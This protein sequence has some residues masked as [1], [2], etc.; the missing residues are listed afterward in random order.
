MQE[1][2]T[3]M[4]GM[5]ENLGVLQ[6]DGTV[7][8]MGSVISSIVGALTGGDDVEA[9]TAQIQALSD[10]IANLNTNLTTLSTVDFSA[11]I[12]SA[13]QLQSGMESLNGA[14]DDVYSS[15]QNVSRGAI[16]ATTAINNL[17]NTA[18]SRAGAFGG[19]IGAMGS[20]SGALSGAAGSAN[21]L[22]AAINAIPS[23]KS[24][25][26]AYNQVG[27]PGAASVGGGGG[28]AWATGGLIPQ[29]RAFG[30]TI[31]AMRPKGSD[32]VPAMLTP[33]EFVLRKKAV[34]T[35]GVPF[36][37]ALNGL[38]IPSAIDRLTAGLRMPAGFGMVSNDNRRIYNNNQKVNQYISTNNP[39]YANR[40]ANRWA[41][42][43]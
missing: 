18:Q 29:Y 31:F 33:G 28:G 3:T 30:G 41:K 4:I 12:D 5:Y 24:V 23:Y 16:Q 37:R 34:D 8:Q 21:A 17:A 14:L 19:L 22:T 32:T 26:V 11:L 1:I 15:L 2:I 43:L 20:L 36:L 9:A 40:R 7:E 39:S 38:N 27:S 42:S 35:L 10:F 6:G 13:S 25:T